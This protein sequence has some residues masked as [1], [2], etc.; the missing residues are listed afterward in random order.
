M[1]KRVSDVLRVSSEALREH[2]VFDG[3]IG[4]DSKFYVDPRLLEKISVPEFQGAYDKFKKYFEEVLD[5]VFSLKKIN[6]Y[7]ENKLFYNSS[8]LRKLELHTLSQKLTFSEVPLAG[9][10]YSINHTGGKGIGSQLAL[11]LARTTL[12]LVD[13]G[14]SDP[15]IFELAGLFEEGI[16]ADR[17][18]DMTIRILLDELLQFSQRVA[19][20]LALTIIADE[21]L[22]P[23]KKFYLPSYLNKPIILVPQYLLT[24]LPIAYSWNNADNI[25]CH[26]KDLRNKLNQIIGHSWKKL[27]QNKKLLKQLSIENPELMLDLINKYKSKSAQPY[28]FEKDPKG[29]FSWHTSARNYSEKFPINLEA[30]QYN[31]NL[32]SIILSFCKHFQYLVEQEDLCIE[33]YDNSGKP[34]NDKF[35]QLIF[36]ELAE[37]Y[38]K[39]N[40][41]E[42]I[43]ISYDSRRG[44]MSFLKI[45]NPEQI[46]VIL[47]YSSS[48]N[49]NSI[50]ENL[51]FQRNQELYICL[52]IYLII[53]TD[54]R[55]SVIKELYEFYRNE[56]RR[57]NTPPEILV[58]DGRIRLIGRRKIPRKKHY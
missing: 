48:R 55:E 9:L 42:E 40:R 16:G 33:L 30:I 17:I 23:G 14:I 12:E 21:A 15:T 29:E 56:S 10:G 5:D 35:A 50:Y 2:N 13:A 28:D 3:F 22:I 36:I 45:N 37:N 27:T 4:I 25:G 31:S 52:Q 18:S 53:K 57:G 49:L 19:K 26:N 24:K 39:Q 8:E 58:I 41:L 43:E 20:N 46:N 32:N 1:P 7:K 51:A 11:N 34:I 38:I 47:K 6:K 54:N 44:M